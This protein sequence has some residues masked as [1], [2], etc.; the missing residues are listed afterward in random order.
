MARLSPSGIHNNDGV[1]P[2]ISRSRNRDTNHQEANMT[3]PTNDRQKLKQKATIINWSFM[4]HD[5]NPAQ[6]YTW[7]NQ[8]SVMLY[9]MRK[10]EFPWTDQQL[11]SWAC[12]HVF[13]DT[14]PTNQP[15]EP[16]W[17]HS[18]IAQAIDEWFEGGE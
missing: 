4:F 2:T 13:S 1:V 9:L 15:K 14:E 3:N 8:Y 16:Q 7:Q 11:I 17:I 10:T 6:Y 18:S 5:G 12:G